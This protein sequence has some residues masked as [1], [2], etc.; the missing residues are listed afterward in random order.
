M[1]YDYLLANLKPPTPSHLVRTFG[2]K[3]NVLPFL[4][5]ANAPKH[6]PPLTEG[7]VEVCSR[8]AAAFKKKFD[9]AYAI[10]QQHC[11]HNILQ[12]ISIIY[13]NNKLHNYSKC[14]NFRPGS[15]AK[16]G[17]NTYGLFLCFS[18]SGTPIHFFN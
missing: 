13:T 15:T 18:G 5:F 7:M 14:K 16:S 10:V 17:R 11:F 2:Q 8:E 9:S 3:G 6:P 4:R 12:G 1:I